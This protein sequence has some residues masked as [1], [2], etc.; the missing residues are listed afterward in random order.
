MSPWM[1]IC[2][3]QFLLKEKKDGALWWLNLTVQHIA[4][5]ASWRKM[6]RWGGEEVEDAAQKDA[7][8]NAQRDAAQKNAQKDV[9]RKNAQKDVDRRNVQRDVPKDADR[10]NVQRDVPKGVAELIK[11][12]FSK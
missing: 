3:V 1:K 12:L 4:S 9:D 5:N 2:P 7:Q 6:R 8:K 10:K 11:G